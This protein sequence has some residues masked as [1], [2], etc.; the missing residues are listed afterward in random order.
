MAQ[1]DAGRRLHPDVGSKRANIS[2]CLLHLASAVQWRWSRPLWPR[3]AE[4]TPSATS[5]TSDACHPAFGAHPWLVEP[6]WSSPLAPSESPS[7]LPQF[8]LLIAVSDRPRDG[9]LPQVG[10]VL[11]QLHAA[12]EHGVL[13]HALIGRRPFVASACGAAGATARFYD[14]AMGENVWEYYFEAV[15]A[16]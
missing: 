8:N 9:L 6:C 5:A 2:S 13:A 14:P 11:H 12:A 10:R 4:L 16:A 1:A 3:V 15:S 7:A